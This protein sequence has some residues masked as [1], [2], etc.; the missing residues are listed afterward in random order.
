MASRKPHVGKNTIKPNSF[1]PFKIVGT[2]VACEQDPDGTV[3]GEVPVG[4]VVLYAKRFGEIKEYVAEL[5]PDI[6]VQTEGGSVV[7]DEANSVPRL[8][9]PER[10]L[11]LARAMQ[12]GGKRGLAEASRND[13]SL[14]DPGVGA[15][16]L[17]GHGNACW[18]TEAD[19][20]IVDDERPA[21]A[22]LE[23]GPDDFLDQPARP[24]VKE[25]HSA[26]VT[27]ERFADPAGDVLDME[28]SLAAVEE[29]DLIGDVEALD[30]VVQ[31]QQAAHV[32][33]PASR[34]PELRADLDHD[35]GRLG[36]YERTKRERL[37]VGEGVAMA[38]IAV[39]PGVL[40]VAVIQLL[41]RGAVEAG[42]FSQA[43]DQRFAAERSRVTRNVLAL[44]PAGQQRRVLQRVVQ[45]RRQPVEH[46]LESRNTAAALRMTRSSSEGR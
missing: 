29:L 24:G 13:V 30:P 17:V 34:L 14:P 32:D 21:P 19:P 11:P 45:P 16:P 2:L 43:V 26:A 39:A 35:I 23:H 9:Q 12:I 27:R 33:D 25:E 8:E 38:K 28:P 1:A 20:T 22:V 4:E 40:D 44:H 42:Q 10:V 5:W 7:N 37:L 18:V 31:S 3:V 15:D 6:E 36:G 41:Q 46:P